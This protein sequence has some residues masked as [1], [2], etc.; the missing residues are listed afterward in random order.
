MAFWREFTVQQ[1]VAPAARATEITNTNTTNESCRSIY[2]GVG[3]SY[4]FYINGSWVAFKNCADGTAL[5]IRATGARHT[6]GSTAP[7]SGDI[8]FLY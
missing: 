6:S 2:I 8:L 4:D 3:D 7:D 5:P 1:S